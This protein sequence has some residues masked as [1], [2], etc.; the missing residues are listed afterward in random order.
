MTVRGARLICYSTD[1]FVDTCGLSFEEMFCILVMHVF[2]YTVFLQHFSLVML[3]YFD[4]VQ[5][6][7]INFLG[8]WNW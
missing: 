5:T 1:K 7:I 2:H 8:S 4:L 6:K 3:G